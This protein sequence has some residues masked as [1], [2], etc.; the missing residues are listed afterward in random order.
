MDRAPEKRARPRLGPEA[1][2]EYA[3]RALASR[4]HTAAELKR[5]L[6]AKALLA[7]DVD[8]TVARL[9]QYGYLDDR[10]LAESYA[11]AR[12]ERQ[13]FGKARVLRDLKARSVAPAVAERAVSSAYGGLPEEELAEAYLNRR[14]L[15]SRPGAALMDRKELASAYRKLAR[16]GFASGVILRLLKRRSQDPEAVDAFEPPEE[17]EPSGAG[18]VEPDF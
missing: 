12:L 9:K 18:D 6:R 13:G 8:K 10:K 7:A 1:L 17:E 15:R 16:A 5:K 11:A 14:I 2:F 4:A 3:V